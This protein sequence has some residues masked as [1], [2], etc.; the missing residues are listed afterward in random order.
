MTNGGSLTQAKMKE[1]LLAL[2]AIAQESGRKPWKALICASDGV[3]TIHEV[4]A[5]IRPPGPQD[6]RPIDPG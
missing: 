1:I 3:V 5:P 2:Q 4:S 6:A